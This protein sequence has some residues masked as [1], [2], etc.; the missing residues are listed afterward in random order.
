MRCWNTLGGTVVGVLEGVCARQ[1]QEG[2]TLASLSRCPAGENTAVR[3]LYDMIGATLTSVLG[4]VDPGRDVIIV[5]RQQQRAAQHCKLLHDQHVGRL[6]AHQVPACA[7]ETQ[8]VFHQCAFMKCI[9]AVPAD[10]VW[11]DGV[12]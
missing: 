5:R 7:M 12:S 10:M 2:S 6:L 1:G 11:H 8:G 3:G 4:L 9:I